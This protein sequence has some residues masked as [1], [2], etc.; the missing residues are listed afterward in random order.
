[1]EI[2]RLRDRRNLDSKDGWVCQSYY[3]FNFYL[4]TDED[5]EVPRSQ[6]RGIQAKANKGGM[7]NDR[8]ETT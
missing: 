1:M 2:H 5:N 3:Y 4:M 8:A 6:L 7:L